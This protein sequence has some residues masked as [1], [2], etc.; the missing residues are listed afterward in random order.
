[1]T[2]STR[3]RK[4][5]ALSLDILCCAL[6]GGIFTRWGVTRKNFGCYYSGMRCAKFPWSHRNNTKK[7][8]S[9]TGNS[10]IKRIRIYLSGAV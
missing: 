1:M 9:P 5:F 2:R 8:C 10:S 6:G 7:C 4:F 3:R